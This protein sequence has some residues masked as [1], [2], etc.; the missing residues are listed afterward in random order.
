MAT[1]QSGLVAGAPHPRQG[2][3]F[4]LVLEGTFWPFQRLAI[5]VQV[6][7]DAIV[8]L[9]SMNSFSPITVLSLGGAAATATASQ[10]AAMEFRRTEVLNFIHNQCKASQGTARYHLNCLAAFRRNF[11][12]ALS[13]HRWQGKQVN[14]QVDLDFTC[15]ERR[16]RLREMP[17]LCTRL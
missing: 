4:E 15:R 10:T 16:P 9:G 14:S 2:L 3:C 12:V 8:T 17:Y 11:L 5:V 1:T 13:Q 7:A 6:S